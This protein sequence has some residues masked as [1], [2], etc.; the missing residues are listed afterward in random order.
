MIKAVLFDL[1]NTLIDFM[2]LKKKSCEAAIKAMINNG[3]QL[4]E[5]KAMHI[6]F[7]LYDKYGIEHGKIFQ[8]FLLRTKGRIDWK[9]LTAGIVA[10]RRIQAD[11]RKPYPDVPRV[12]RLLKNKGLKLG[13]VSDAP[14][15][16]AWI[17]LN[18]IKIADF[19]D[20]VIAYDETKRKK[21][22]ELPFRAAIKK[23]GIK[24]EEILF[25]GDNPKNDIN[26]AKKLGMK[27]A[28]ALY[29]I[30]GKFKKYMLKYRAD[31]A[32]NN[33]KEILDIVDEA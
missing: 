27:T 23:L 28:L 10:Y 5:K 8:K 33:V 14:S 15:L 29:G 3:L 9:I 32:I 11:Y 13:V 4:D 6:L 30:Q 24:P 7:D 22:H 25:V 19:F 26:G 18:E 16:K 1:D 2:K 31:Y 12:L 17:R 21:P 20:V